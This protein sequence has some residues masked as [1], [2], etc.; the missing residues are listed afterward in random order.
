MINEI[1]LLQKENSFGLQSEVNYEIYVTSCILG[2]V[3]PIT[4]VY[5]SEVIK[6]ENT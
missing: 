1:K 2:S 6:N 3:K 5:N 4:T